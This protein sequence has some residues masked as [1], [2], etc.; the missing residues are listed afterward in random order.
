MATGTRHACRNVSLLRRTPRARRTPG[1][2][3]TLVALAG[4]AAGCAVLDATPRAYPLY[5]EPI[6][7]DDFPVRAP[8]ESLFRFACESG[9][10]VD[11]ECTARLSKDC[12]C[13]C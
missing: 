11:C 8:R 12:E 10:P 13:G 5:A 3:A 7:L 1:L 6:Y 9:A 4:T 2:L